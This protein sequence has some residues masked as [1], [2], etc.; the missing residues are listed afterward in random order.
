MTTSLT[1]LLMTRPD[2]VDY[3]VCNKPPPPP[4]PPK[5]RATEK[6]AHNSFSHVR[7]FCWALI[8]PILRLNRPEVYYVL[9]RKLSVKTILDFIHYVKWAYILH[10][11]GMFIRPKG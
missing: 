4:P 11:M 2:L 7:R 6:H 3:F 5:K 8:M 9:L 10:T 1:T